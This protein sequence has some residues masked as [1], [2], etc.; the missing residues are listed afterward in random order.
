[1]HEAKA[2]S[3][4]MVSGSVPSAFQGDK[5]SD[6]SSYWSIVSA[7][8]YVTLT[9]PKISYSINKVCQFMH[10]PTEIHWQLVKRILRYLRGTLTHELHL[11]NPTS[12]NLSGFADA[13]WASDHDDRKSTSG[14]SILFGGNPIA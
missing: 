4:L 6:V 9:R 14:F 12:L 1:M 13:D 10:A 11:H 3:T 2:I 7:L 5:F 8:K